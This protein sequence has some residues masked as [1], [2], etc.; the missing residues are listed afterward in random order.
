MAL[1]LSRF[2]HMRNQGA[3]IDAPVYNGKDSG[4]PPP[5]SQT[6]TQTNLPEYAR[7][8]FERTLQRTEGVSQQPYQAYMGP[9]L[10]PLN[11]SQNM[12]I[13]GAR[14]L[15]G[16]V[17]GQIST[18]SDLMYQSG[19]GSVDAAGRFNPGNIAKWMSPYQQGVIDISKREAV[20]SAD[21]AEAARRADPRSVSALG[22]YRDAI[23]SSEANRNKQM[24]LDDI[25]TRGMQDAYDRG[26]SALGQ[27]ATLGIQGYQG[28]GA[29]AQGLG[30]LGGMQRDI[31]RASL[32]DLERTGA[33]EQMH[34]Q[35]ALD[36]AYTD[37]RNAVD[38]PRQQLNF[39]SGILRG[40]P[41]TAGSDVTTYGQ[42]PNPYAQLLGL[43][44]AGAGVSKMMT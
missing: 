16:T 9:R 33:L 11:L 21:A 34:G 29:A 31:E 13:G 4:S 19:I 7:P 20:R 38:F 3:S 12:A 27:E 35:Q 39:M 36:L 5:S 1:N 6:V 40:L 42:Q 44:I 26:V 8:Y 30:S 18:A 37:F 15:A 43:G 14:E 22:G 17:P 32:S 2:I 10:E 25:Q 23:L 28:M 41:V 24:L